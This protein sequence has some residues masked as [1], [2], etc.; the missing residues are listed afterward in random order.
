VVRPHTQ[1]T[2]EW[3]A[4]VHRRLDYFADLVAAN[5][6]GVRGEAPSY[7]ISWN[8][9]LA[10]VLHPLALKFHPHVQVDS[11]LKPQLTDYR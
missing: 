8:R 4:E 3:L 6:G 1:L 5:P 10:Q 2:A 11:S 9:L 7:P